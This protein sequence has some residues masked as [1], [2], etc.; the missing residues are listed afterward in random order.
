[1]T[2]VSDR[3]RLAK[4]TSREREVLALIADGLSNA[5]IATELC[6]SYRTIKNYV[7]T[8]LPKLGARNRAHAAAMW[9]WARADTVTHDRHGGP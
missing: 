9:M 8:L 2:T 3:D 7:Y 1:M 5:E 4:L 6:L